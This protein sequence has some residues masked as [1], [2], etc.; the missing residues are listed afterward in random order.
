MQPGQP[1]VKTGQKCRKIGNPGS[2]TLKNGIAT[3]KIAGEGALTPQLLKVHPVDCS[4]TEFGGQTRRA[5]AK[6]PIL[7][8]TGTTF[9]TL[10]VS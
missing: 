3:L 8:V 6:T 5:P 4:W 1:L 7:S 9:T 10:D 2:K